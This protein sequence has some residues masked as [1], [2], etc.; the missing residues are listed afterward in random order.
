MIQNL[1]SFLIFFDVFENSLYFQWSWKF[2]NEKLDF[3]KTSE[4]IQFEF[5]VQ[6]RVHRKVHAFLNWFSM[7][8]SVCRF[9][10]DLWSPFAQFSDQSPY[11]GRSLNKRRKKNWKFSRVFYGLRALCITILDRF[12][13]THIP[14]W[15]IQ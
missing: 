2:P 10:E 4:T 3:Q 8:G 5:G 1:I 6:I 9:F 13:L 11:L 7:R 12:F 14:L 15:I